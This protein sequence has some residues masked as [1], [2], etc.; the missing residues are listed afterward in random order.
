MNTIS[1]Y[2]ENFLGGNPIPKF[3]DDP[4]ETEKLMVEHARFYKNSWF[5]NPLSIEIAK[6]KYLHP[7]ETTI[8]EFI[9]RV[10]SIFSSD[11]LRSEMLRLL[12]TG[13]FF[14]GGRSLYGAGSKGKF[15]ATMSNCYIQPSPYQ[16]SLEAIYDSNKEIA[17]IFKS[18]GG[19]GIDL[20]TLRPRGAK[21]NNAARTST[22]AVSFMHV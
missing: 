1:P 13:S 5:S 4:R 16:D 12:I 20:S 14:P 10:A 2:D 21:T 18:G 17:K 6:K 7:G 8:A 22:G 9:T 19:I 11:E 3:I 15:N